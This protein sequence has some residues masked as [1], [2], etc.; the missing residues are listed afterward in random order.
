MCSKGLELPKTQTPFQAENL[1]G[2]L[3][4]KAEC[5]QDIH[6]NRNTLFSGSHPQVVDGKKIWST[7][8]II[9]AIIQDEIE[10]GEQ[11]SEYR[12]IVLPPIHQERH[13]RYLF[14]MM[15]L[16][17]QRLKSC[18]FEFRQLESAGMRICQSNGV[19]GTSPSIFFTEF[20]D[21]RCHLATWL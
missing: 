3:F 11:V 18:F 10:A 17:F 16:V 8:V 4:K 9:K 19:C 12:C 1:S 20:I 6:R 5:I 13:R 2:L 15:L 7:A 14:R 21:S